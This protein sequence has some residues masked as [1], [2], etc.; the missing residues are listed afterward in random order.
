[1]KPGQFSVKM[2]IF[3]DFE[4]YILTSYDEMIRSGAI[5]TPDQTDT[6]KI[7]VELPRED[8]HGDLACNAAMVLSKQARMK[9]RE[10]AICLPK[11]WARV[12]MCLR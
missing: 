9:P 12:Q 10:L 1:M 5:A 6:S 8:A 3:S 4:D 11:S 2:N 7:V